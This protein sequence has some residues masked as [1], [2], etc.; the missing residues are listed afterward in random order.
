M[1]L[2]NAVLYNLIRYTVPGPARPADKR[3]TALWLPENRAP[4]ILLLVLNFNSIIK[5]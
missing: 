1:T 5:G 3:G 2:I 4:G